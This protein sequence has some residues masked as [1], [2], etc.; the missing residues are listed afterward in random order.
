[1]MVTGYWR[2][3]N[4][5]LINTDVSTE[6]DLNFGPKITQMGGDSDKSIGFHYF[7][8][9]A[10]IGKTQGIGS[11]NP[12]LKIQEVNLEEMASNPRWEG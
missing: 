6:L 7:S 10:S 3:Q 11:R 1:M 5:Y 4:I 9:C 12:R 8:I 2:H